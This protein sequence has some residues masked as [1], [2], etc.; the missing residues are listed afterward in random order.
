MS[1]VQVK[2]VKTDQQ[3]LFLGQKHSKKNETKKQPKQDLLFSDYVGKGYS[4]RLRLCFEAVL[5][6]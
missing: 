4:S 2:G 3:F 6:C 5:A 1:E